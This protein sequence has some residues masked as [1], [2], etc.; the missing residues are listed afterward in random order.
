M[1]RL[2]TGGHGTDTVVGV[3][4]AGKSTLMEACRIGWDAT[5]PTCARTCP[6]AVAAQNLTQASGIPPVRSWPGWSRSAPGQ[7]SPAGRRAHLA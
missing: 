3:A 7:G 1:T 5:G 6:S 4:G 2:L